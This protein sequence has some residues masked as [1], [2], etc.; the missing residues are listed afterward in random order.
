MGDPNPR[1]TK[2]EIDRIIDTHRASDDGA[3]SISV[4]LNV[5][6]GNLGKDDD[7]RDEHFYVGVYLPNGR[8]QTA[9][10][11]ELAAL[12]R[13]RELLTIGIAL[14]QKEWRS[15]VERPQQYRQADWSSMD[16]SNLND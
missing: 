3:S 11:I 6:I 15:S 4:L 12:D 8:D 9:G 2:I 5:S 16:W 1:V 10:E 14:P 13:A 7:S